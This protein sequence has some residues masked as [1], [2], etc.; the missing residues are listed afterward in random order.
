MGWF[1]VAATPLYAAVLWKSWMRFIAAATAAAAAATT[2][3]SGN[4]SNLP[5]RNVHMKRIERA[6][7]NTFVFNNELIWAQIYVNETIFFCVFSLILLLRFGRKNWLLAYDFLPHAH[8]T[9]NI[10]HLLRASCTYIVSN[11]LFIIY[12]HHSGTHIAH[13]ILL[14]SF[15][16][17]AGNA[18]SHTQV[19]SVY[20][21]C[22]QCAQFTIVKRWALASRRICFC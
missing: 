12:C 10:V 6:L 13:F 19:I 22:A 5:M 16:D 4:N 20:I 15:N 21:V 8:C 1:V 18:Q 11:T 7:V 2:G 17:D 3:T 9:E 14:P